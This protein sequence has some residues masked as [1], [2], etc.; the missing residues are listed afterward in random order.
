ME[1]VLAGVSLLLMRLLLS[2]GEQKSL[3][4]LQHCHWMFSGLRSSLLTPAGQKQKS[5]SNQLFVFPASV[6]ELPASTC[7]CYQ[8]TCSQVRLAMTSRLKKMTQINT[9]G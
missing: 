8:L 3:E 5:S 2:V 4:A 1:V 6:P 9:N 7:L